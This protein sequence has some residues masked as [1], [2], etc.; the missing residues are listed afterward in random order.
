MYL[1]VHF[2][3][4]WIQTSVSCRLISILL[5]FPGCS[6]TACVRTA[7]A[8]SAEE[9][10]VPTRAQ[11]VPMEKPSSRWRTV[12][13]TWTSKT[14]YLC[15]TTIGDALTGINP[16]EECWLMKMER[17]FRFCNKHS[18]HLKEK[19]FLDFTSA[20]R[21]DDVI[22]GLTKFFFLFFFWHPDNVKRVHSPPADPQLWCGSYPWWNMKLW[23]GNPA[24]GDL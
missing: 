23:A 12:T 8:R 3:L 4:R 22:A 16:T 11:S 6:T 15:P 2:L 14:L 10:A 18:G 1:F 17:L 5:A 21:T 19:L 24:H 9:S 7:C 20:R 13:L